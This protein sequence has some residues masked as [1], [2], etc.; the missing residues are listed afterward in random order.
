MRLLYLLPVA[1]SQ[2]PLG[3]QELVR[4]AKLLQARAAPDMAI[5]VRD[6]DD[7]PTTIES[8]EDESRAIS[9]TLR[10]VV[11]AERDGFDAVI[12]GCASDPGVEEAR[13]LVTIPIIGPAEASFQAAHSLGEK[14]AIITVH[15]NVVPLITKALRRWRAQARCKGVFVIGL[16]VSTIGQDRDRTVEALLE[17]GRKAKQSSADVLVLGCM[18]VGFLDV[19]EEV[20]AALGVGVVC[21][22]AAALQAV[23]RAM[24]LV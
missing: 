4:R 13:Q 9:G 14:F 12:I 6:T 8:V 18:S 23:Y 10:A 20:S 3:P 11:A 5:E 22:I 21:P 17:A 24:T 2:G 7:G 15:D 1:M 16:P 19:A